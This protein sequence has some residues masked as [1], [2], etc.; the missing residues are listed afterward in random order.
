MD[1]EDIV[2]LL[3]GW[4]RQRS[5][6]A[7]VSHFLSFLQQ[8]LPGYPSVLRMPVVLPEESVRTLGKSLRMRDAQ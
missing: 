3:I 7:L 4:V 1:D 8:F 2:R 5:L 6:S